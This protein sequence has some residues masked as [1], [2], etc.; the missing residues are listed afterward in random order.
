[1]ISSQKGTKTIGICIAP[2]L[3]SS[4]SRS[5]PMANLKGIASYFCFFFLFFFQFVRNPLLTR[6]ITTSHCQ[7]LWALIQIVK[8]V[9]SW[10][11]LSKVSHSNLWQ[12][13]Q[14]HAYIPV[15]II[16]LTQKP[17][18]TIGK[19]LSLMK[20]IAVIHVMEVNN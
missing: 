19:Q 16:W 1:M 11:Y 13:G 5:F 10:G 4:F 14:S 18:W 7:I 6:I 9:N 15:H 20:L 8:L 2:K 17:G 3:F 12:W